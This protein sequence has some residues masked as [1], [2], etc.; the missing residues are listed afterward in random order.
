MQKSTLVNCHLISIRRVLPIH[1]CI[2]WLMNVQMVIASD[3][4]CNDGCLQRQSKKLVRQVQVHVYV[5]LCMQMY[6]TRLWWEWQC[7]WQI[8]SSQEVSK[9]VG[10]YWMPQWLRECVNCG[11]FGTGKNINLVAL[12]VLVVE[13]WLGSVM[14][15]VLDFWST[16]GDGRF[17]VFSPQL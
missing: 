13:I 7:K 9:G 11:L 15:M 16:V 14:D 1:C 8:S 5:N 3:K 12:C 4:Q 10:F 6:D 2:E 17:P